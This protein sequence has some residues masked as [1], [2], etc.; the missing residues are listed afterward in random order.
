MSDPVC[1][2]KLKGEKQNTVTM[3]ATTICTWDHLMFFTFKLLPD[4]FFIEKVKNFH[5]FF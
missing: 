2:V 1:F 3:K 5:F 4:E